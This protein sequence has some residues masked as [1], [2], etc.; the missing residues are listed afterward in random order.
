[1][2]RLDVDA[3]IP[4]DTISGVMAMRIRQQHHIDAN[5]RAVWEILT[6]RIDDW[7]SH[8]YRVED[9][10]SRMHLEMVPHGSLVEHWA[11]NGFAAW[12]QVSQ[13]DPGTTLELTG[14]CGMGA[15]HGVYTFHLQDREGGVLLTLTH[16]AFGP[17]R[18]EVQRTFEEAWGAMMARLKE[19]AEGELAYGANARTI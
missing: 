1:M 11:D 13:L 5:R 12:G 6:R 16:D 4:V 9:R 17:I 8:P 10:G 2:D 15:V 19:L 7:W 18:E 14:P 3:E